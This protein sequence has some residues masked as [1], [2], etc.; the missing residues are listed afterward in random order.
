M[1]A[2]RGLV[3]GPWY[4]PGPPQDQALAEDHLVKRVVSRLVDI[5]GPQ[6]AAQTHP[7]S[8]ED[9]REA[10]QGPHAGASEVEEILEFLPE[11]FP[12]ASS[13]GVRVEDRRPM[14]S[15]H[16]G[17]HEGY[18]DWYFDHG[19]APLRPADLRAL[20]AP[21]ARSIAWNLGQLSS[22]LLAITKEME[23]STFISMALVVGAGH[24][25]APEA[26][27]KLVIGGK[28]QV[29]P[30]VQAAWYNLYRTS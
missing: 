9:L 14:S 13:T 6:L 20:A 4:P 3:G 7:R 22:D 12:L 24:I 15:Q 21:D 10:P 23:V 25:L 8:T 1:A 28:L 16:K 18:H 29:T 11:E 26:K 27:K 30:Q 5:L 19:E 17:D 2:G